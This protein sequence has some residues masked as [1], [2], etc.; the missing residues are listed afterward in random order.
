MSYKD[1]TIKEHNFSKGNAMFPTPPKAVVKSVNKTLKTTAKSVK[2]AAKEIT[3]ECFID[4]SIDT[5]LD[6]WNVVRDASKISGTCAT[7]G[8]KIAGGYGATIGGAGCAT[9]TVAWKLG[10]NVYHECFS[11]KAITK[12]VIKHAVHKVV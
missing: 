3:K 12:N 1:V 10:K 7:V 2:T 9:G 8:G 4:A 5:A 11:T 6:G